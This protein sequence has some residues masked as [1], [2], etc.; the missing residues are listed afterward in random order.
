[1]RPVL[2][3]RAFP[4]HRPQEGNGGVFHPPD[5]LDENVARDTPFTVVRFTAAN[6]GTYTVTGKF[7]NIW[8]Q[9]SA[10]PVRI[11]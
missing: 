9:R 10:D 2:P 7:E 11:R 1:M 3:F 4:S 8:N 5:V 6:S